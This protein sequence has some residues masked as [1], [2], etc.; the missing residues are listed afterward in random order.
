MEGGRIVSAP[1]L[2][3]VVR[4]GR[5]RSF[6]ITYRMDPDAV[7]VLYVFPAAYPMTH[8]DHLKRGK[9]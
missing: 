2:S 8:P 4:A 5:A 3:R 6:R 7:A 1:S 9:G